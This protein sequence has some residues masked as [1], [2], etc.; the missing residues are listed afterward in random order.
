MKTHLHRAFV[1]LLALLLVGC[2]APPP[3]P[4]PGD[5]ESYGPE[6]ELYL[7]ASWS[8]ER[9]LGFVPQFL[10]AASGEDPLGGLNPPR[11]GERTIPP[12]ALRLTF[13]PAIRRESGPNAA[14]GYVVVQLQEADGSQ[15]W[16]L[17]YAL[18]E[19]HEGEAFLEING[20]GNYR[21]SL[22]SKSKG[23]SLVN[24]DRLEARE[25]RLQLRSRLPDHHSFGTQL[26]APPPL[27]LQQVKEDDPG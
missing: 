22:L 8:N 15:T 20:L 14:E 12:A 7:A 27:G 23:L 1:A 24:K 21:V 6:L 17:D 13:L 16:V 10:A 2:P 5:P 25:I 3:A 19:N 18:I 26:D 11:L 4:T 9:E